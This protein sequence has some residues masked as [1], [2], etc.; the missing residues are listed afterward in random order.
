VTVPLAEKDP[1]INRKVRGMLP[2]ALIV[3]TEL[4]E[5]EEQRTIR[6]PEGASPAE[7]YSAYYLHEHQSEPDP[8][9]VEAF[10]QL[11]AVASGSEG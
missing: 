1:D 4:P 2:N 8:V 5:A 3:K 6:P 9:V 10:Q 7:L 11:H